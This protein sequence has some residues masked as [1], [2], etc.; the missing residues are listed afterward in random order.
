M[1]ESAPRYFIRVDERSGVV[2]NV[3]RRTVGVPWENWDRLQGGWI[4][5]GDDVARKLEEYV[6]FGEMTPVTE[7]VALGTIA[8]L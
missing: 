5:V 6:N 3:S 1:I 8:A 7:T 4:K 2:M